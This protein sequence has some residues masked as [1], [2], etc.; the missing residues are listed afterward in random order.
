M[1]LDIQI[2]KRESIPF[3]RSVEQQGEIH[4]LGEL[5][6]FSWSKELR[7]FM[8]SASEF[9]VSWVQ[10]EH[11]EI[12]APHVHPIQSM[13][14]VYAGSGLML[15]DLARPISEG[16][17]IVVP[18]GRQHGFTGGPN[19]LFA[20]S[21]QFGE[22]LYSTPSEPRVEFTDREG[23]LKALLAYNDKRLSEF[24][25][26]PIFD[27]LADG[28]LDDPQLRQAYLDALQIWVDGNQTLLFSRQASCVEAR[29]ASVFLK[30]MHDEMGHDVMH[31]DRAD[32]ASIEVEVEKMRDPVMEALT[33]WFAYQMY[34]LDNAEKTAIIHLVIENASY[35]Y[36]QHAKPVLGKYVNEH[37]FDVHVEAD[38][39]HAALGI[40]LLQNESPRTYARLRRIITEAW[41]MVDAMVDRVVDLTRASSRPV[42]STNGRTNHV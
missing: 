21:I 38:D 39:G 18:A 30:H 2:V 31:K 1:S 42:S 17:V 11:G 16:D 32:P 23:S 28:T 29:Y 22:G 19:G 24:A 14:V 40:E 4:N 15:G 6:D 13:M 25:K 37:Y 3:L 36:H 10:L 7:E 35:V 27:L 41:D 5:R 33:N 9:S 8:P 12:L 20:L 26:R 34:V